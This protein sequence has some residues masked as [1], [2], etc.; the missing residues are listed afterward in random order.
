MEAIILAGGLGTR[1]RAAVPDLPKPMAP[2]HGR[3]F[4]EHQMD[5]W[6]A[7]GVTRFILS[8]G[9][10]RELIEAH[11]GTAYRNCAVVYAREEE[12][13]GTG[14]GLLLALAEAQT[15]SILVLNGDTFFEVALDN[16]YAQHTATQAQLTIALHRVP[17]NDRYGEVVLN[18]DHAIA[19]FSAKPSGSE[20]IINGGVY[21]MQRKAMLSLGWKPGDKVALEQDLFPALLDRKLPIF[22]VEYPGAFIDIGVPE[23]YQRAASLLPN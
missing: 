3:P 17:H 11:F 16:L 4:L 6:I 15:E 20:G 18:A 10:K 9:Y 7:Q 21:M 14:G 1:L 23:D 22:G 5:Y 8:V 2:I 19:A 12:P 13:L